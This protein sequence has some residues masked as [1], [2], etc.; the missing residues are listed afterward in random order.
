MNRKA[1]IKRAAAF[2]TALTVISMPVVNTDFPQ[3][4][5]SVSASAD[6]FSGTCGKYGDN[7]SWSLSEGIL[8][9][10][11]TG[12]MADFY[13]SENPWNDSSDMIDSV[14]IEDGVTS[15]GSWAFS[16][17]HN[18]TEIS[19]PNSV[20]SIGD[21]AFICCWGLSSVIIPDSVTY[22][23]EG[24]F[25]SC[26]K[27]T[28][29]NIPASVTTIDDMAF[30]SCN[31][32][33]AINA[34]INNPAYSSVDGVLFN[35]DADKIIAYPNKK[36][37]IYTVPDGVTAIGNCAFSG[38]SELTEI[39]IPSSVNS[40]GSY[41]FSGCSSLT[42]INLPDSITSIKDSTFQ[43]CSAL[44]EISLPDGIESIERYAFFDCYE[45]KE[46]TIPESVCSIQSCAFSRCKS[47][48]S[49]YIPENVTNI[50]Q[51]VFS[52]CSSLKEI[53]VS[54]NNQEYCSE[55]G[56]LYNKDM[57]ELMACPS[58]IDI[59]T[60][61]IPQTVEIIDDSAFFEN[62]YICNV[63]FPESLSSI[64]Y[65]SFKDC[66]SLKN[67]IFSGTLPNLSAECLCT[68]NINIY[69]SFSDENWRELIESGS[70]Y[71]YQES[72]E[73]VNIDDFSDELSIIAEKT[74]LETGE[75][76]E[77]KASISP[78]KA[79]DFIWSVSDNSIASVSSEG[80]L[81]PLKSGTV[82]V[83]VSDITGKY[84][85]SEEFV[86]DEKS[87]SMPEYSLITLDENTIDFSSVSDEIQQIPC[88]QL[89]GIYFLNRN[90]LSFYSF[91]NNSYNDIYT[92][93]D[94]TS[95]YSANG[96]L[97][98][99]YDNIC[100]VYN[101]VTM[102]TE[103]EINLDGYSAGAVG[104]D[105]DGRIYI[106]AYESADTKKHKVFLYSDKG[107]IISDTDWNGEIC[108]FDGFDSTNGNFYIEIM[109][110]EDAHVL[111]AGNVKDNVIYNTEDFSSLISSEQ[112]LSCIFYLFQNSWLEHQN[113]A[114]L[115]GGKYLA[116]V[117]V[118][119]EA[120]RIFDSNSAALDTCMTFNREASESSRFD[121]EDISSIGVRTLYNSDNDSI[122]IYENNKEVSEYD[123][124][125]H[126]KI[127]EFTAQHNVFN[128]LQ[129]GSSVILI[130]KEDDKYF[131][132]IVDWSIPS[133][134]SVNPF[135]EISVGQA[136]VLSVES[137][138][139]YKSYYNWSSSNPEIASVSD[140]GC[141]TGWKE[142]SAEITVSDKSGRI[143]ASVNVT[144]KGNSD[145]K[146]PDR[147][148]INVS[149]TA[150]D[151]ISCNN[152]L[153]WSNTINSYISENADG[154][155][156]RVEFTDDNIL[157]EKYTSDFMLDDSVSIQKEL[158]IFGGFFSG[159]KYNFL[160]FGQQNLNEDNDKEILRIVK[161]SKD[162]KR[163]DSYSAYGD[164]TYIPFSFGS[165][166]MTETDSNLYVYTCHEMY[167]N[168]G[169]GLH[170]QANMTFVV[171]KESMNEVQSYYDVMNIAQ[172]GYVSHSF[173]QFI[174]TDNESIYRV[175]HGDAYPRAV[176]ITKCA[177]DGSI[178]DVEWTILHK[179]SGDS[180]VNAT[181]VSIGGFE[182]SAENCL[183]V[184]NSVEQ[185]S[186]VYDSSGQ[187]NI[188]ISVTDKDLNSVNVKW[189]TQYTD[190][191]N[192]KPY[193]PQLVKINDRQF[194]VMWEEYDTV[195]GKVK[196]RLAAIDDSGNISDMVVSDVRLSDCQP[197]VT[198]DGLIKWY[199]SDG[200]SVN[201]YCLNPYDILQVGESERNITGDVNGDGTLTS[202]DALCIL[203]SV[204]GIL[205]LTDEQKKSADLD[206]DGEITSADA[207]FILQKVVGLR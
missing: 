101:L 47:I 197:V 188:F 39:I 106:S 14:V 131:M 73:W 76:I 42:K 166:R 105:D 170:H 187:R 150:S 102:N 205:D 116:A 139:K 171:D 160:V 79:T 77:L 87:I 23:G 24:S 193:T 21:C 88:E 136:V 190:A 6:N 40:I 54:E 154:T 159:E 120:V 69:C 95:A 68:E 155:L 182:L 61:K 130:E 192:I 17:C 133:E 122:I 3:L 113:S 186:S 143:S 45:L 145:V 189:L 38:C 119:S 32:L 12:E 107:E 60:L 8:T 180:G 82:T 5:V 103:L 90:K 203:Q 57:T 172:A 34:D 195:T 198:S 194:L 128:M 179:I 177:V 13:S 99:S 46:I 169:E 168:K 109:N 28:E 36:S 148:V 86:I 206:G 16:F 199:V 66:V 202:A 97:Y 59:K 83:T 72:A 100:E 48:K 10:S 26:L 93:K 146:S 80:V 132:E 174:K 37:D 41:A 63:I 181:G 78:L 2:I 70:V 176:T 7:I 157:I 129:M 18:M 134:I 151:N 153:V 75:P 56:I 96:R 44:E 185:D 50:E 137:D 158:S 173:N 52:S 58:A 53:N 149:G 4:V 142:G 19:V 51:C 125:T 55:N 85:A 126:D 147:N 92:F 98:I 183:V 127:A 31:S 71:G 162:W 11:G 25:Q 20:K 196:T 175:D 62:E 144:I 110:G 91:V 161:Y 108:R 43:S 163:L 123:I 27:L 33:T 29:I 67:V 49:V 9:I 15:I 165:L 64:G 178:T 117:S 1:M 140:S 84:T 94:C 112:D 204:A 81:M 115:L 200:K 156:S 141:V 118:N 191:D 152:Y 135:N 121:D 201:F 124:K 104:A 207:L 138:S 164:N 65:D 30:S 35:K 114:A 167:D 184:G 22:I 74:T 89:H 111:A